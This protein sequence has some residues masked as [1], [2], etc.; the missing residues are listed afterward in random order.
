MLEGGQ[1]KCSSKKRV[2]RP[3][4]DSEAE[5]L[6]GKISISTQIKKGGFYMVAF[7]SV[8]LPFLVF[9]HACEENLVGHS[10]LN[11]EKNNTDNIK[12]R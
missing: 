3:I 8:A 12:E 6:S 11:S 1:M 2:A 4:N 9:L 7:V 5:Y 10:M